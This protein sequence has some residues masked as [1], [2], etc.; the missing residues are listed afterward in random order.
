MEIVKARSERTAALRSANRL[1]NAVRS[2][3][4]RGDERDETGYRI[5]AAE[6]EDR[7]EG[8]AS[9]LDQ[10]DR[11]LEAGP[12]TEVAARRHGHRGPR[13]R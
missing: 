9:E 6:A 1:S 7:A 5:Q 8:K 10:P 12:R 13:S 11:T 4:N 3:R 2:S